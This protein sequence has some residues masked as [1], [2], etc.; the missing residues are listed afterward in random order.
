MTALLSIKDLSLSF[1]GVT[2]LSEVNLDAHAGQIT[3]VIGPN[4]AGKTSL[5]NC[6]SGLYRPQVGAIAFEGGQL[7]G[8]PAREVA[9]DGIARTFQNLALF[10]YLTV[11]ENIQ[12]GRHAHYKSRWWQDL[13]FTQKTTTEE[14]DNREFIEEIIDFLNLE[15]V[16]EMP[17]GVLP[18]GI[19][20]RVELARALAMQPKLLLLDEPAAGLNREATEDLARYIVDIQEERGIGVLL[21]EHDLSFVF[22]LAESIYVLDFGRNI[23]HGPPEQMRK[24]PKVIEVYAGHTA[25]EEGT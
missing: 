1:K 3:A 19:L 11:L 17:V 9:R 24:D 8:K 13:F 25:D 14:I 16:R 22:D 6:I 21:I 20:K 15:A 12:L 18:Y 7:L 4:G 2:A 23:A 10:E 5:F